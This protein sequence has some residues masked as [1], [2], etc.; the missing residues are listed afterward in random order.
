MVSLLT[1]LDLPV[2]AHVVIAL[3]QVRGRRAFR[4]TKAA[5]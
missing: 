5:L 1:L 2:E 3:L 4:N